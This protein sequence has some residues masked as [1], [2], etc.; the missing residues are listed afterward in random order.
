MSYEFPVVALNE[1]ER[2]WLD[3]VYRRCRNKEDLDVKVIRV[4][5]RD[6]LPRGFDPYAHDAR[7]YAGTELTLLGMW[8]A[9]PTSDILDKT[10]RVMRAIQKAIFDNPKIGVVS[11]LNIDVD[12]ISQDEIADIFRLISHSS[13]SFVRISETR[14]ADGRRECELNVGDGNVFD[15]FY[16]YSGLDAWVRAFCDHRVSF[17][18][19]SGVSIRDAHAT[20]DKS[21]HVVRNTAFILMRIDPASPGLEDVSNAIKEVCR[22][23]D[24]N[25][26]RADDIE[27]QGQITEV[28]LNQ[29]RQ[30]E[31]LVADLTDERPNVYY[32]VGYA[33]AIGK[34]PVLIRRSGTTI[35]FDLAG[36]RVCEYPNVTRLKEMM[37]KT[38]AE[39]TSKKPK[40]YAM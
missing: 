15:E 37:C 12:G 5:L 39:L 18:R 13:Q 27:H 1:A 40:E 10:D 16:E 4:A 6:K 35:H 17:G 22:R 24:I 7:L 26:V 8:H 9:D 36:Y 28:V 2:L 30:A 33:H 11:S 38:F 20:D 19:S 23:F 3:E 25:A 14:G 32:E 21:V 34:R 31:F 29:I